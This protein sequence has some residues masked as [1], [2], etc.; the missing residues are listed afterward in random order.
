MADT[1]NH[2]TI[3]SPDDALY[4]DGELIVKG[5][6]VQ[7]E[8]TQIINKL[9]SNTLIINS[10]GSQGDDGRYAIPQLALK[11]DYSNDLMSGWGMMHFRANDLTQASDAG[12]GYMRFSTVGYPVNGAIQIEKIHTMPDNTINSESNI[13]ILE[14]NL[15]TGNAGAAYA[16]TS[17]VTIDI[18]SSNTGAYTDIKPVSDSFIDAGDTVSLTLDLDETGVVA[19]IYGANVSTQNRISVDTKGRIS[20]V[21][22]SPIAITFDQVTGG[23]I[24]GETANSIYNIFSAGTGLTFNGYTT[25]PNGEF[26]ITDTGVG[27]GNYGQAN[28]LV[29]FTVN[30]QGQLT[31]AAN[32]LIN[33]EASQVSDFESAVEDL[34]S[35]ETIYDNTSW[36]AANLAYSPG[37]FT[38]TPPTRLEVRQVLSTTAPINYDTANGIIGL[39]SNISKDLTFTG[40]V[41]L[42]NATVPGFTISGNLEVLGNINAV[43]KQDLFVR[44]ANIVMNVG[45]SVQDS[46]IVVDRSSVPG[47]NSYIRWDSVSNQWSHFDGIN[48]WVLVRD[49]D[50]IA[51]GSSNLWFTQARVNATVNSYL[52]AGDGIEFKNVIG[53]GNPNAFGI[54]ADLGKDMVFDSNAQIAIGSNVVTNYEAFTMAGHYDFETGNLIIPEGPE[55]L[56]GYIYTTKSSNEAFVYMNGMN[57]P[58]TPTFDFGRVDNGNGVLASGAIE[59]YAGTT[60]N[61]VGNVNSNIAII[62]GLKAGANTSIYY[63]TDP[64]SDGNVIIIDAEGLNQSE[65]RESLDVTNVSGF[66]NIT[67]SNVTGI[68]SYV[69]TSVNDIRSQLSATGLINYNAVSGE[70]TTTADNYNN[71]SFITD[72]GIGQ[73]EAVS[74]AE[75]VSFQGGAGIT[76]SNS[77]NVV[78]ITNTNTSADITEV[79]AGT[80]LIGGGASGSVTLNIAGGFGITV[81]PDSIELAN[82][83]V[84]SLLSANGDVSYNSTTGVI[85]FTQRTDSEVRSLF[86]AAG[87]LS[88]NAATGVFSFTNDAGDIESVTAGNGLIGGGVSGNV[89]LDAV[90]GYGVT[91]NANNIEIANSDVRALLTGNSGVSYNNTTGEITLASNYSATFSNVDVNGCVTTQCITTGNVATTGNIEG[92]WRLTAGSTL[93]S[94]YADIAEKYTSDKTY[95]TGT[96]MVI[97]MLGSAAELTACHKFMDHRVAGVVSENPAFIMNEELRASVTIALKG[98]VPVRVSGHVKKGDLLV[99]SDELG[100]ATSAQTP[101]VPASAIV[102]IA[103]K[104]AEMGWTEVKV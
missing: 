93:H 57:I 95:Q 99:T 38:Y 94:T 71:W 3:I 59:V 45:N 19:G 88:Y 102:G 66:G 10:D 53:P 75:R 60:I 4:I 62:R 40:L 18:T 58:I 15:W 78:T 33:I 68:F 98:R 46:H 50:D 9:E 7:I 65:V 51:E 31:T 64:A 17:A 56:D 70:I 55:S 28:S 89:T 11:Y 72:D 82:S 96:V 21:I 5:N 87:D 61:P 25:V 37:K 12:L 35:A 13:G 14:G 80:G 30:A 86:S 24:A 83:D 8:T 79:I 103:L 16:M 101:D 73:E 6:I 85:D 69:G 77:G 100:C 2:K 36:T 67:Y 54:F 1:W 63:D 39:D 48:E 29:N 44:D 52:V 49:T 32:L 91:V 92:Q 23:L 90:G 76:V 26:Y 43:A 47:T 81:N 42:S 34:F 27:A 97:D 74:S 22:N 41:D 104:D 84:R 20:N